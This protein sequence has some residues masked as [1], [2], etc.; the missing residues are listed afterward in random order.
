MSDALKSIPLPTID[1]PFGVELWPIFTKVWMQFRS[2]PPQDFRFV[3]GET[4]LSTGWQTAAVL[5]SYYVIIFGGRELMRER[6][7]IKLNWLFK[8]HNLFLTVASAILLALFTEQL[9]PV[10]AR[11]G[12]FYA[13]CHADGGWTTRLV[14]LYYVSAIPAPEA[15]QSLTESSSTTSP[16]TLSSST[17]CS[18]S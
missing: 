18:S 11:R 15:R 12:I 2:F 4:P 3:P 14:T 1:R 10:L 17:P 6:E 7:A 13:I 9:V 5:I 16:S 8:V